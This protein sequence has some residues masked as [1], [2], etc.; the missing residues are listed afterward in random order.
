MPACPASVTSQ[1]PAPQPLILALDSPGKMLNE[2]LSGRGFWVQQVFDRETQEEKNTLTHPCSHVHEHAGLGLRALLC[3]PSDKS[4]WERC[5][6]A[7]I[8]LQIP[9]SPTCREEEEGA[10]QNGINSWDEKGDSDV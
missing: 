8:N 1:G 3:T 2:P 7:G 9:P 4:T 5:L 10:K 6:D